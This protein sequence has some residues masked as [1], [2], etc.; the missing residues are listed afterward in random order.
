MLRASTEA[1]ARAA[2]TEETFSQLLVCRYAYLVDQTLATPAVRSIQFLFILPR[3]RVGIKNLSA[4]KVK[5]KLL[6]LITN[7]PK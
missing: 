2:L 1:I 4:F 5:S 6:H 7:C 3:L